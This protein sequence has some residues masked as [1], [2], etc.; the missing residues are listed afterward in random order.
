MLTVNKLQKLWRTARYR[1]LMR[2][3]L[4]ARPEAAA[5]LDATLGGPDAAAALVLLRLCELSASST[6]FA[7]ELVDRLLMTQG[8]TGGWRGPTN[9][10]CPMLT[11]LCLRALTGLPN[12]SLVEPL[13]MTRFPIDRRPGEAAGDA[14]RLA[15]LSGG[16]SFLRDT[17][18]S[19]G[20]WDAGDPAIGES[21]ATA[22]ILLQLGRSAAFRHSV[23]FDE[24]MALS[25][26]SRTD[27][28]A[29][30]WASVRSRCGRLVG[31]STPVPPRLRLEPQVATSEKGFI[32]SEVA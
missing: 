1:Q 18:L 32:F 6:P 10:L 11:A 8:N 12:P 13:G 21:T 22:F 20:G 29:G 28:A 31:R 17:Q 24:A 5:S 7:D 2:E 16:V 23:R 3:V 15:A 4:A 30:L 9:T 27:P 26:T 19:D 14:R 25:A